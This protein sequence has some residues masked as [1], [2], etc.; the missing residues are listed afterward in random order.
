MTIKL[1][2]MKVSTCFRRVVTVL[3]EKNL[4]FEVVEV[5]IMK[6]EQK[7]PDFLAKQPFGKIP[8]LEDDGFFVYES[9]AIAKYIAKKYAG[10]GTKLLPDGSDVKAIALFEQACSMETSYFDGPAST[11]AF[12]KVFKGW[13]KMGPADEKVVAAQTAALDATFKGYETILSKQSY[14]GGNELTLADLFHLP[15]GVM[16]K[17]N[18]SADLF[19][20][21]PAVNKWFTGLT[22]RESWIKAN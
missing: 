4:P 3:N 7:S 8:V 12:E 21:Y 17:E 10:Q 18:G 5:N 19:E 15:Y 6:G 14:L 9:R 22:E 13:K 20:K 16:L 11:M 1:Y 2:G